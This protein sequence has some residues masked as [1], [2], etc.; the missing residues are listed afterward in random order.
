M[1]GKS[2]LYWSRGLKD[3]YKI[4]DKTDEE[5]ATEKE[6]PADRLGGID[7]RDWRKIIHPVDRRVQLLQL[8]E[9]CGWEEAIQKIGIKKMIAAANDDHHSEQ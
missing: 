7:W 8:V 6:E 2:Q 1:H 5:V 4:Q 9:K 3:R